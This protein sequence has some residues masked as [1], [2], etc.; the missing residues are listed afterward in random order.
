[1]DQIGPKDRD[2]D[3]DLESGGSLS[4]EDSSKRPAS[5]VKKQAKTLLAKVCGAFV[6]ESL[7]SE[8]RENLLP[9]YVGVSAENVEVVT[10]KGEE[11]SNN[12]EKKVVKQKGQK[13]S[14]KKA[15]KPPRPPR[16][17]SLDATDQKLIREISELAMLKRAR[18][19]RMKALKKMKG[20]KASSSNSNMFAMVLTV[21]FCVVIIF[22]GMSSRGT[23]VSFQGSSISAGATD[24]SLISVQLVGNPSA[25]ESNGLASGSP[26]LVEQVAGSD[27]PERLR[28]FMG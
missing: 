19:E 14:N 10:N 22:Q 18:I 26:N 8:D 12:K 15:P 1:M 20:A 5:C 24:G 2:L 27:P 3:F 28:R 17:P 4:G 21:I 13:T 25:S 6:D 11:N 9:N 7:K 23:P 16:G